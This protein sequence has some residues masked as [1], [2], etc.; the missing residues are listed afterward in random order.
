MKAESQTFL[1]E[2][3]AE[4]G[5]DDAIKLLEEAAKFRRIRTAYLRGDADGTK[6]L[7]NEIAGWEDD[8][9]ENV[10]CR[11][12]VPCMRELF[13]FLPAERVARI[14]RATDHKRAAEFTAAV[15]LLRKLL[16]GSLAEELTLD[17]GPIN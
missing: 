3:I 5:Q 10:F 16:A 12:L 6:A 14:H 17:P 15:D 2:L 1:D 9:N 4:M 7:L 8:K 13:V 11:L